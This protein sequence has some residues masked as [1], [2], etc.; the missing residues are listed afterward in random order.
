MTLIFLLLLVQ[1][2]PTPQE[3]EAAERAIVRLEPA[4]FKNL[5]AAVREYLERRGCTIPQSPDV[6]ETPHNV[7]RGRFT[8]SRQTDIAVLCS[9]RGTSV[10]LVFRGESASNVAE[11]APAEDTGFLQTIGDNKI[12]F[13]RAIFPA[14]PANIRALHKAFGIGQLPRI[15]HDGLHDAYVGKASTILYWDGKKWL[16]LAGMD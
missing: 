14:P 13:S 12:G 5:P 4:A 8:S 7:I 10:I 9:V 16:E 1:S 11:L 15:D 3:W 2:Q 6:E